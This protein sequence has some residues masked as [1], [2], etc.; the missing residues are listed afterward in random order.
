MDRILRK[1][2]FCVRIKLMQRN[3]C[4][5]LTALLPQSNKSAWLAR[6]DE[7][8]KRNLIAK[9][10]SSKEGINILAKAMVAPIRKKLDHQG[11]GR[12][13]LM[14]EEL[15]QLVPFPKK[16]KPNKSDVKKKI[17][18]VKQKRKSSRGTTLADFRA[19]RFPVISKDPI[20]PKR[21]KELRLGWTIVEEPGVVMINTH[22]I[23]KVE[24]GEPKKLSKSEIRKIQK[25]APVCARL[26]TADVHVSNRGGDKD[27]RAV[28]KLSRSELKKK[29][30][31]K[32]VAKTP[33]GVIYA[34]PLMFSPVHSHVP[35]NWQ[36]PSGSNRG[37][38]KFPAAKKLKL[39]RAEILE[40]LKRQKKA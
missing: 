22:S 23:A 26:W 17:D 28:R 32:P 11:I 13:L 25:L 29:L 12:K 3:P 9:A 33:S 35:L 16:K 5:D 30:K 20:L 34:Q 19:R 40:K 31:A 1:A 7:K 6:A 15:P 8:R 4:P 39:S 36:V 37:G 2:M 18:G 38:D 10:L 24:A 14:V 27:R 21:P